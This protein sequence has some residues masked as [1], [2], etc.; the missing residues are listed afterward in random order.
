MQSITRLAIVSYVLLSLAA[1]STSAQ[2]PTGLRNDEMELSYVEPKNPAFRPIYE[3]LKRRQVLEELSAFMSPLALTRKLPVKIDQCGR[4]VEPYQP[5]GGVTICYEFIAEIERLA[6][7]DKTALGI[8]RE[9]AI[10]GAFIQLV[11]HETA[12][13]V[14]DI[15]EIP[16]WGREDDAADRLAG[17]LMVQFGKDIALTTLM[18]TAHFFDASDHTWT[19][20][21]FSDVRSTEAQR[22]FNYLCIAYGGPTSESFKPFLSQV[23][24]DGQ[25]FLQ[26]ERSKRCPNEY[27]NLKW[28]F[29]K[30]ILPHVDQELMA[31][32]QSMPILFPGDVK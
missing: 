27:A 16:V 25:S 1:Q 4:M 6:P 8:S 19:G 12:H 9:V 32:V 13:A 15:L 22:F 21:D 31:K 11:L 24:S 30:T 20:S 14:F 23:K 2:V 5:G 18:G 3:R 7:K 26:L 29:D 10:A 28:A 17:F